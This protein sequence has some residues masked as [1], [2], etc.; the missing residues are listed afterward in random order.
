[1]LEF[2]D[3]AKIFGSRVIF[4]NVTLRLERGRIYLLTGANGAGKSTLLRLAAGLS[5]PTAGTLTCR[6]A[7]GRIAYMGHATFIYPGLTAL[8]N[9]AFWQKAQN[10]PAD[11]KMLMEMLER[12]GLT[13]HAHDY[14]GIFSR[15]MAQRLNLAR[16]LL[17]GPELRLLDEPGTGLD[18][19]SSLMLRREI[20]ATGERG[21]T[22]LWISH[23][24][25]GDAPLADLILTL[26]EGRLTGEEAGGRSGLISC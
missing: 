24:K 12:V 25:A 8:E 15:G 20:A 13:R 19:A 9:L 4:K 7:P 21:A 17:S 14:A 26:N 2:H 10:L 1:M 18:A 6:A 3:V 16:V 23:D 11:E 5:K 22:A